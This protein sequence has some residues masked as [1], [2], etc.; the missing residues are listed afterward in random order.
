MAYLICEECGGYYELEDGESPE[1]LDHCECGGKLRYV[2]SIYG[3]SKGSNE[4]LIN[5]T[6]IILGFG[7]LLLLLMA[8]TYAFTPDPWKMDMIVPNKVG[9]YE[10]PKT[11]EDLQ[12]RAG[13]FYTEPVKVMAGGKSISKYYLNPNSNV[14]MIVGIIHT[15][16]VKEIKK[17]TLT[18]EGP[19][20]E[21][22]L[23]AGKT[24]DC[25]YY[26]SYE[27]T[28]YGNNYILQ[29]IASTANPSTQ[30]PEN[31][32]QEAAV[33]FAEAFI[34]EFNKNNIFYH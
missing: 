29:I 19:P 22:K 6:T 32:L 2:K 26:R 11:S 12:S 18:Y 17:M 10:V 21:T 14:M 15:D 4:K 34:P 27:M 5:K 3:T 23:I 31:V 33:N 25:S 7:L 28:F 1:D 9:D 8:A 16:N 30:E 13:N 20:E 24:F